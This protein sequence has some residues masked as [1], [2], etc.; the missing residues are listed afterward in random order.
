MG[1]ILYF[2]FNY[3]YSNMKAD[4]RIKESLPWNGRNKTEILKNIK[5]QP[6]AFKKKER[7][8]KDIK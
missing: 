6:L 2:M 3:E 1:L 7:I 4:E 8:S 5:E